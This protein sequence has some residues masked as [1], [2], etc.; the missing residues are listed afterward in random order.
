MLNVLIYNIV[1][2]K[3]RYSTEVV[4]NYLRAQVDN[5]LRL[6]WKK[7]EI[8]IGTNFQFTYNGV[9]NYKLEE[10][11]EFNVFCN[12]WYGMNELVKK[13]IIKDDFWFHDQDSWQVEKFTFPKI[14]G[15]IGGCTY[16]YNEEWNTCSLFV[17]KESGE[18]LDYIKK[19]IE[20]NRNAQADSDENY[21]GILR[22]YKHLYSF[23]TTLKNEYNVG[24]TKF[25]F[26]YKNSNLPVYVCGFKPHEKNDCIVFEGQNELGI[27]L[28]DNEIIRIFKEH[29]IYYKE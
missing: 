20:V 6:G 16:V 8:I 24:K 26:R 27:N 14:D 11:S 13:E 4:E 2:D 1:E 19:F 3:H 17:K 7:D 18:L 9:S 15:L 21:I 25:E 23:F 5:S 29:K 22:R 28:L 10:V 12:K